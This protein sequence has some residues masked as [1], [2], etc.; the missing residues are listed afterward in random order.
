MS[1]VSAGLSHKTTDLE[2]YFNTFREHI[3]GH[4]LNVKLFVS[5]VKL[6]SFAQL[7][8]ILLLSL[9]K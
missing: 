4:T 7:T 1:S 6:L 2:A 9:T 3:V 5:S 8:V